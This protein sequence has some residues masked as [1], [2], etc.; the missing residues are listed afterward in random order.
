VRVPEAAA[1]LLDAIVAATAPSATR[2]DDRTTRAPNSTG[3][4]SEDADRLIFRADRPLPPNCELCPLPARAPCRL[5]ASPGDVSGH[6]LE[7]VARAI[8]ALG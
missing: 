3:Q 8:L 5:G 6:T 2:L 7:V 4:G 1:G